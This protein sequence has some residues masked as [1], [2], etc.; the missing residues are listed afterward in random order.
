[1]DYQE[2][3]DHMA[4]QHDLTLLQTE[5][6]EIISICKRIDKPKI[7][8]IYFL[9]NYTAPKVFNGLYF[10]CLLTDQKIS[11]H[12]PIK[13]YVGDLREYKG[14]VWKPERFIKQEAVT[15]ST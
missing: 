5:M 3:F 15:V 6:Q 10:E 13:G 12:T 8:C 14:E 1:M 7:G 9:E 11:A 4:E 2:L